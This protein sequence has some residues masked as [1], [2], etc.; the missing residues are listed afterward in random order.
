MTTRCLKAKSFFGV[1]QRIYT[2]FSSS[3]KRWK[4][5]KENVIGLTL[6]PLSQTRWESYI[7]SVRAIRFQAPQ[8]KKALFQL[9]NVDD[10]KTKV[11]KHLQAEDMHID[12]AI[13]HLKC[14]ISFF[15]SYRES[16]FE[17]AMVDAKEIASELEIESI[18]REKWCSC[19]KL[20]NY[21][22]HNTIFD[23]GMK[24]F[25]ELRVLREAISANIFGAIDVLDYI[26]KMSCC[27]A[28]VWIAYRVLLTIPVTVASAERSF[29]K[30][31]LIK[32]YLRS[33]M[34]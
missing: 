31:K 25:S 22:K 3:T 19:I 18:F 32:S 34:S 13:D 6:K 8:I 26:K 27:Y 1:V 10:S 28:N 4:V 23:I 12:V 29:S 24:L 15:K 17:S 14:L 20:E 11:S 7:E 33:S 5:F 2:L 16:G 21:L 9:A 30:F